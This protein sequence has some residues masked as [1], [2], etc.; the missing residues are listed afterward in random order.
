MAFLTAALA[1]LVPLPSQTNLTRWQ[2]SPASVGEEE[3]VLRIDN[4]VLLR[5]LADGVGD[6]RVHRADKESASSRVIMRS[7]TRLPVAGRLGIDVNVLDLAAENA[8][9]FVGLIDGHQHAAPI[10]S[11]RIGV[12]AAGVRR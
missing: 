10:L 4:A 11:A 5:D 1:K 6:A 3:L 9:A 8:A 2:F 7:A 12:L